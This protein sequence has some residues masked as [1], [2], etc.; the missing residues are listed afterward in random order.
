VT[1]YTGVARELLQD[2]CYAAGKRCPVDADLYEPAIRAITSAIEFNHATLLGERNSARAHAKANEERIVQQRHVL[3]KAEEKYLRLRRHY[4]LMARSHDLF[5]VGYR[6]AYGLL[7]AV[8][9]D[10][11][12]GTISGETILAIQEFIDRQAK[13]V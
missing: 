9:S 3:S 6:S 11:N 4:N 2:E 5:E 13:P 7:C 8:L 12:E 10:Y 1:D